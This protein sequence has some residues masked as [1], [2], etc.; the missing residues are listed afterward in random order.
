MLY[1]K[2]MREISHDSLGDRGIGLGFLGWVFRL[3]VVFV[4]YGLCWI[5]VFE[6]PVGFVY[7]YICIRVF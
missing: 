2:F 5:R 6:L 4:D 3:P 7:F 1:F